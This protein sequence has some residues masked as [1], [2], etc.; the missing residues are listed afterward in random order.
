[1]LNAQA[2]RVVAVAEAARLP[3]MQQF[4]ESVAGGA[5]IAY[6][7]R[8]EDVQRQAAGLAAGPLRG[9]TPAELPVERPAK[10]TLAVNRAA[11][12]RIGLELPGALLARA[13][14]VVD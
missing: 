5:L 7:P 13:D 4:P 14:Q 2:S 3:A 12:R 8:L 11:A 10:V 1:M 9:R 6:G